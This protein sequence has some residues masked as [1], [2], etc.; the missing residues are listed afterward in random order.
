MGQVVKL[1]AR[2]KS[3]LN[4]PRLRV[5]LQYFH[6]AAR[7]VKPTVQTFP[8]VVVRIFGRGNVGHLVE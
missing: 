8:R 7:D 1:L 5:Q 6:F 2:L 3:L 4:C